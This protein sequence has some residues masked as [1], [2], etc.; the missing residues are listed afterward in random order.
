MNSQFVLRV[1]ARGF[2][3]FL[4]GFSLL[5]IL[6]ELRRTGFDANTWWIDFRPVPA[7]ASR[8]FLLVAA[9]FLIA[10]F[11]RPDMSNWRRRVTIGLS[12]VLL[13]VTLWNGVGF[14]LAL[15]RGDIRA[16]VPVPLSLLISLLLGLMYFAMLRAKGTEEGVW[17]KAIAA[18]IAAVCTVGFPAAQMF[19]Y[20]KTDYRRP[21]DAA[22]VFGAR[23][24]AD[25]RPSLA[26]ADRV[27]TGCALYQEGLVGR[28]VF[29]GGPG[30]G[31]F[32]ETEVMRRM[33][34]E[35]GVPDQDILV[36]AQGLNTHATVRNTVPVFEELRFKS[37]LAVSHFYHLPRIKMAYERAGCT[38]YTVPAEESRT[39]VM[40]P[41]YLAREVAALWVYYLRPLRGR[42]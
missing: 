36:D 39:L 17:A 35:L 7:V 41:Y 26:L 40:L 34:T 23:A 11:V 1:L 15:A 2:A 27:R 3:L 19:C 6:G 37:I 24:Y 12:L 38:V 9:V 28:L 4:G 29:S 22:V 8:A 31:D 33:A 21:A 18:G 10:Y 13:A 30:D 16:G 32:H 20:G 25:G 5:N 42:V 14:Y